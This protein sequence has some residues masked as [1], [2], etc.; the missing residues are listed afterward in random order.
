[1]GSEGSGDTLGAVNDLGIAAGPDRTD[2]L[3]VRNA[4]RIDTPYE[5]TY[6]LYN[7][8][9]PWN[10]FQFLER[11]DPDNTR[12]ILDHLSPHPHGATRHGRINPYSPHTNVIASAFMG[13]PLDEFNEPANRRLTATEARE[14]TRLLMEHFEKHG[15][16]AK[17]SAYG[18]GMDLDALSAAI[19]ASNPW[20]LEGFFRNSYELFSPRGTVYAVLLAAQSG[21]TATATG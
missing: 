18:S 2:I 1:M 12:F 4:D 15:W 5:F 6:L 11:N 16:P 21:K 20:E 7:D 14:A 19:G 8:A 17:A 9:M 10:T 3:Y 13:M